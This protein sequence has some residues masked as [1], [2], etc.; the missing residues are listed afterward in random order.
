LVQAVQ[1]LR[2]QKKTAEA[3]AMEKKYRKTFAHADVTRAASA[4]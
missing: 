2:A 3:D 1:A 4:Y